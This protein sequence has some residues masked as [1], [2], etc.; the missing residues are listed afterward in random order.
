MNEKQQIADMLL[1]ITQMMVDS[2][3]E[4]S[5][6]IVEMPQS[7]VFRLKASVSDHEK[8][9]GAGRRTE[10][11]LRN[12]LMVA[13]MKRNLNVVLDISQWDRTRSKL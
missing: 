2:P 5:V 9:I 10:R 8:L 3:D 6:E 1:T 13:G 12:V 7:V 4:V 11:S